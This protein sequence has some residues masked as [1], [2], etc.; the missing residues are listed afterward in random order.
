MRS[1]TVDDLSTRARI[2]D[3]A[4][5]RFATEGVDKTTIRSIAAAA[6][7]SPGLVIH[8]FGSKAALR[9]ECDRHIASY[10]RDRKSEAMQAGPSLDPLAAMR[11]ALDGPP[12][13]RYLAK[14]L[15]ES[16]PEVDAMVDTIVSD[17]AG[18]MEEGVE[19]GLLEPT[20]HPYERAAVLTLYSLGMLALHEHLERLLGVDIFG[21]PAGMRTYLEAASEIVVSGIGTD[22]LVETLTRAF[23]QEGSET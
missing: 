23:A 11:T 4:I 1:V 18:Y 19:S 21:D 17:A 5:A 14:V 22:T 9:A 8:H 2:R 10:L 20:D 6:D 13:M 15:I 16:S 3:A 12:V 7:V